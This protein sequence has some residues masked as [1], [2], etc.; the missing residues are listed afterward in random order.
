MGEKMLNNRLIREGESYFSV[1]Y[2]CVKCKRMHMYLSNYM[3]KNKSRVCSFCGYLNVFE[4]DIL[5]E[6]V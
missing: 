1:S 4:D 2:K 3:P 6:G 5:D